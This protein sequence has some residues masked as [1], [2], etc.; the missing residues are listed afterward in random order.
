MPRPLRTSVARATRKRRC[1]VEKRMDGFR[2]RATPGVT[3]ICVSARNGNFPGAWVPPFVARDRVR[4][5]RTRLQPLLQTQ[6]GLLD[7]WALE[8]AHARA[9]QRDPPVLQDIAPVA[10]LQRAQHVLLDEEDG[11]PFRI[12]ALEI[13]EDELDHHGGETQAR[14][15]EHEKSWLGHEATADGAHLLLSSRQGAPRRPPALGDPGGK[16][17]H[18]MQ[19]LD[20]LPT[21]L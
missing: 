7:M 10:E 14:L 20:T 6:V 11:Q 4:R 2:E 5:L 8:Q 21:A 12:D 18:P 15:V 19:R 13:V 1:R 9:F 3:S 16:R 17:E